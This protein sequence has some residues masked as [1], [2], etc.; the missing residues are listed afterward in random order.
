MLGRNQQNNRL[1]TKC[2]TA[3]EWQDWV[4]CN[5]ICAGEWCHW[6]GSNSSWSVCRWPRWRCSGCPILSRR[7]M[8]SWTF[9]YIFCSCCGAQWGRRW[10]WLTWIKIWWRIKDMTSK[11]QCNLIKRAKAMLGWN[12]TYKLCLNT[13]I[14]VILLLKDSVKQNACTCKKEWLDLV[15]WLVRSWCQWCDFSNSR[16]IC[17]WP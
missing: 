4:T 6:C 11:K 14:T 17:R 12:S 13:I 9:C 8:L 3:W 15:T 16:G 1:D 10:G 5:S 2:S 7:I